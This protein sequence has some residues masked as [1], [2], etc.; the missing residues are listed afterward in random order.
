M[1]QVIACPSKLLWRYRWDMYFLTSL[2]MVLGFAF[3]VC[4]GL[5]RMIRDL[6]QLSVH[7]SP[8]I[9]ET[10][11]NLA[12]EDDAPPE[13]IESQDMESGAAERRG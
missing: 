2:I 4:L 11:G 10:P 5:V 3:V 9:R 8:V 7:E 12:A 1:N 6:S 13:V